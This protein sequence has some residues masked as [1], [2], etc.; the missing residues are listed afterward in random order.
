MG[1]PSLLPLKTSRRKAS[2]TALQLWPEYTWSLS[3]S[4]RRCPIV[5]SFS[6]LQ[7]STTSK[8][9]LNFWAGPLS[10]TNITSFYCWRGHIFRT[11]L[12]WFRHCPTTWLRRSDI[13]WRKNSLSTW[14][15]LLLR[16]GTILS[17]VWWSYDPSCVL[18][19]KPEDSVG[20]WSQKWSKSSKVEF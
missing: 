17:T 9:V 5:M 11:S 15:P 1:L 20:S 13:T 4:Y 19:M 2:K 12:Y 16:F 18:S 6:L 3:R 14:C 7:T 8:I 10:Q